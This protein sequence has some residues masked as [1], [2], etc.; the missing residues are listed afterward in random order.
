MACVP[1]TE[2]SNTSMQLPSKTYNWIQA[3]LHVAWKGTAQW[4]LVTT[5]GRNEKLSNNLSRCSFQTES[6]E[7]KIQ[8]KLLDIAVTLKYGQGHWKHYEQLK[9]RE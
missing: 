7:T 5:G 8:L 1:Y 4:Q 6:Q 2:G 9:L 3:S